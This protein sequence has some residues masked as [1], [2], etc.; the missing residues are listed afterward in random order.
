MI[1]WLLFTGLAI[2]V[3]GIFAAVEMACVSF[4]K[5]RLQYYVSRG[6]R[7]AAWISFLLRRPSRLFGTTLICIN[8]S[9]QMG[10]ECAR[11]FYESVHLDPDWAPIT[12][13]LI[14]VI[15]AELVPMFTARRHPERI[16]MFFAPLLM[17]MSRLLTPFTW[18]FDQFSRGIHWLMKSSAE[19]SL[20]L[21]REEVKIAFEERDAGEADEF[22][23]IV[24]SIFSLKNAAAAQWM[25]PIFEI[26][27]FPST[28]QVKEVRRALK[29]KY[30]PIL[31]I[32]HRVPNN[33]VSI[34]DLRD[35]LRLQEDQKIM[36]QGKPPW[37]V[38]KDT[39]ILQI[40]DQFRRNNQSMAVILEP[41][42]QACGILTLDRIVDGIFG[43]QEIAAE[44]ERP[45]HFVERTLSGSMTVLEFNREFKAELLANP[46][47]TLS[48]LI[49]ASL[50]HSLSRGEIVRIGDFEFTCLEPTLRGVKRLHV[51]SLQE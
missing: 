48:D 41:T 29:T 2:F 7:R 12:Q 51:R 37:F 25:K 23:A 6:N 38:T 4:N 44:E 16:A 15:F 11:R 45:S 36:D 19:T 31:P 13:V 50:D 8:T 49:L 5:I 42:G 3:Q 35:L 20:F 43:K 39:S 9:L 22:N 1:E 46:A 33:I 24:S 10:S 30:A 21:S 26:Q 32:Y 34:V 14:V 47:M 28:A 17:G 18:G 40:I 27:L